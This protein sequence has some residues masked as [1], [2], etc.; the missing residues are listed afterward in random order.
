M[1]THKLAI[2]ER[3]DLWQVDFRKLGPRFYPENCRGGLKSY[4]TKPQA[5]RAAQVAF[6][7]HA[8]NEAVGGNLS[9]E[10]IGI[11]LAAFSE[12]APLPDQQ[13]I[14]AVRLLK[15]H[16]SEEMTPRLVGLVVEDYLEACKS[17]VAEITLTNDYSPKLR[18]VA[19][20]FKDREI[21]SIVTA[22]LEYWLNSQPL[23]RMT[24]LSYR[25]QLV[26]VWQFAID[27]HYCKLNSAKPIKGLSRQQKKK[28]RNTPP[29]ILC[30]DELQS[31]LDAALAHES[32]K[33]L[34][35]FAVTGLSGVRPYEARKLTWSDLDFA[36]KMIHVPAESSKTGDDREVPMLG[37]LVDWLEQ[38][39]KFQRS[40]LLPWTR[41]GF[42]LVRK[43]AGVKERWAEPKGADILRHSAA[44]HHCRLSGGDMSLTASIMGHDV[45]TFRAHYKARVRTM[46]E[47]EQYFRVSPHS[48]TLSIS[49][50][51]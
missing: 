51:A 47:A 18:R 28:L 16:V 26:T 15:D 42:D 50:S 5:N 9:R 12:L 31:L 2:R 13:L 38:I 49:K 14:E 1:A 30:A 6:E 7:Q 10:R 34:A 37:S 11:A 19:S 35:Y 40:G 43:H 25:N 17:S 27:R 23:G 46:L 21:H 8:T 33:M 36:E 39:P 48:A 29:A 24:R 3:N 20:A 4:K 22:E 41:H 45:M 32:A 44:S